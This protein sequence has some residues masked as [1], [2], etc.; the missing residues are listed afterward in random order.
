[1]KRK[2]GNAIFV[3]HHGKFDTI[4]ENI[5]KSENLNHIWVENKIQANEFYQSKK[6]DW[7]FFGNTFPFLDQLHQVSKSIQLGHGVGPKSS[8]YTKSE[9]PNYGAIC[10]GKI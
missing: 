9:T 4:I 7:I 3:F 2:K 5:I 6:A 1:M 10:G 8:Y